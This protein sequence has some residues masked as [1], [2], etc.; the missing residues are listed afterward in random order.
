MLNQIRKGADTLL[1]RIILGLIAIS[2][3][4]FGATEF[5]NGNSRGNIIS[6]S[7]TD[8]I[9]TEEFMLV[10]SREIER[11]QKANGINL[12][13]EQMMDKGFD[14]A[15]LQSLIRDSM[16]QYLAKYYDFDISEAKV[17]KFIQKF[18][19]F[20]NDKGEFDLSLFKNIFHN[21]KRQEDEY[22][23]NVKKSLLSDAVGNSFMNSFVPSKWMT[24]N[25][26][27]YMAE[28]KKI[29]LIYMDLEY[30]PAGFTF[31]APADKALEELYQENEAIFILPERRSFDYI[32]IAKANLE[33]NINISDKE[34]LE[35]YEENKSDFTAAD[36]KGAQK[37]V[38]EAIK[39][40]KI[41]DAVN[42]FSKK[43]ETDIASGMTL[44]EI[45][46]KYNLSISSE[47]DRSAQDLKD[48]KKGPIAD[49]ADNIFE[50]SEKELSYPIEMPET[51]D[52]FLI[53]IA[54]ITQSRSRPYAEVANQVKD[55]WKK[56]QL[57][58]AN[59]KIL[60]EIH[61]NY[62]PGKFFEPELKSRG[63]TLQSKSLMRSVQPDESFPNGLYNAIMQSQNAKTTQIIRH[64]NKL[65]FAYVKSSYADKQEAKR[66]SD[67]SA[68]QIKETI[69]EGIMQE[70]VGHL[71]E[72]NKM[73]V[74]LD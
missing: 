36:F 25:V 37:E 74:N 27:N 5:L 48:G 68:A 49:F 69:R 11:I 22:L 67:A 26:I 13:E 65:Y 50:M 52:L 7:D 61:Q 45:A 24:D 28:G 34:L 66:I 31:E 59:S 44:K 58:E 8:S 21:S 57:L 64:G 23:N 12:T 35:Y 29:D 42:D 17:V 6:F 30:V 15:I 10:K 9:S 43:L 2:F 62:A 1:V 53:E 33:K 56:N 3:V 71:T 32:K 70:I 38:R 55:M 54:S 4:G 39:T 19:H 60:T 72:V 40:I 63:I 14:R 18:P 51:H 73:K 20:K 41:E 47:K 46:A 16:I